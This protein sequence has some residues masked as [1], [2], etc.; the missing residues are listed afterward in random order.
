MV[1][2]GQA[3]GSIPAS[4]ELEI[5]SCYIHRTGD[6]VHVMHLRQK[7]VSPSSRQQ[8]VLV[9]HVDRQAATRGG[10]GGAGQQLNRH[11]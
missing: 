10:G 8:Y 5:C 1:L 4:V 9:L 3:F 6:R 2:Q 7:C 11:E